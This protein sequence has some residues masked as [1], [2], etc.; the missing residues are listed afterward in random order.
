MGARYPDQ[1]GRHKPCVTVC[2]Y[3]TLSPFGTLFCFA[4]TVSVDAFGRHEAT[5]DLSQR[6]VCRS[7]REGVMAIGRFC[8]N[9]VGPPKSECEAMGSVVWVQCANLCRV[10]IE[11]I[12]S[13]AR[14]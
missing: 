12:D 8:R 9:A 3:G 7:G 11:S 10:Y 5:Q 4:M 1:V 13:G 14:G 6:G 2:C